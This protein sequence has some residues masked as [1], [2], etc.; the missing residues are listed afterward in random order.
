LLRSVVIGG[1]H[2]VLILGLVG[3]GGPGSA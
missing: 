2:I 1:D 3:G